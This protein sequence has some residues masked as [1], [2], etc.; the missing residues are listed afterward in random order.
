MN[1]RLKYLFHL[2]RRI[3]VSPIDGGNVGKL[4][5]FLLW[6]I[7]ALLFLGKDII[8]ESFQCDFNTNCNSCISLEKFSPFEFSKTT[9]DEFELPFYGN[10][11]LSNIDITESFVINFVRDRGPPFC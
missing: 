1:K 9:L 3:D 5:I 4:M 2:V 7:N 11:F 8:N 10:F 6:G